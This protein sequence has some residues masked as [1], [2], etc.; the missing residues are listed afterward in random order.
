M[1][2]QTSIAGLIE[3]NFAD[4]RL[5]DSDCFGF[6]DWF[7]KDSSLK[8][9][10]EFLISRLL[11]IVK[12][13]KRFDPAK[14]YVFF[15]NN[16]ACSGRLYDDFRICDIK[17]GNVL[18]TITPHDVYEDGKASVWSHENDFA[19]PVIVGKWTDVKKYFAMKNS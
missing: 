17:T 15:K 11:G 3:T 12:N 6:V 7:C 18:Y 2:T 5:F 14:C 4:I 1:S 16:C 9:K 8:N 13:N 10:S 19:S